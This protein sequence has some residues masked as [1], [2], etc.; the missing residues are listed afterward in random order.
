MKSLNKTEA[1][2][3]LGHELLKMAHDIRSPISAILSILDAPGDFCEK[4]K[5]LTKK[6]L[7]RALHMAENVLTTHSQSL[8]HP[9][10]IQITDILNSI[11][12][13]KKYL[14]PKI[15]IEFQDQSKGCFINSEVAHKL[16]RVICCILQNAIDALSH[17]HKPPVIHV[18]L[19]NRY[20]ETHINIQDNANGIPMHVRKRLGFEKITYM[21]SGGKGLGLL[22]AVE[23]IKEL[24]GS[25]HIHSREK[26]GTLVSIRLPAK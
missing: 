26:V 14:N 24:K 21:K 6:A 7:W 4:R 1:S 11:I 22:M 12:E 15:E 13:E 18:S 5:T 20:A 17:T 16:E 2:S 10:S 25:L 19:L 23:T 8:K 3:N 9:E